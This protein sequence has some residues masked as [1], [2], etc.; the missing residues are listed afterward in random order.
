MA[1]NLR[2]VMIDLDRIEVVRKKREALYVKFPEKEKF[3]IKAKGVSKFLEGYAVSDGKTYG[4][5]V[6]GE[7][8]EDDDHL[9]ALLGEQDEIIIEFRFIDPEPGG[10]D[11]DA[12]QWLRH[13]ERHGG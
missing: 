5:V 10:I 1:F 4:L 2:G 3:H 7:V 12:Y 6:E 11:D 8:V 13:A 9:L